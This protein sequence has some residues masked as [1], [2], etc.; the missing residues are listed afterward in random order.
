MEPE[1]FDSDVAERVGKG[2]AAV[3]RLEE[4]AVR[5]RLRLRLEDERRLRPGDAEKTQWEAPLRFVGREGGRTRRRSTGSVTRR[6]PS[7][8]MMVDAC[9]RNSTLVPGGTGLARA[10]IVWR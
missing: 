4:P 9:P 7:I 1:P 2:G 3:A 5:R 6:T 10:G 8:S